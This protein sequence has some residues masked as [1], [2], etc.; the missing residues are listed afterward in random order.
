VSPWLALPGLSA[1]HSHLDTA[2]EIAIAVLL[3]IYLLA[4]LVNLYIPVVS[5][6]HR[7]LRLGPIHLIREFHRCFVLL[8]RDPLG[9]VSLAVTT[10]F[11]GAGATLR[12]IILSW[13]ALALGFSLEQATQLTAV[14]AV[15]IAIGSAVAAKTV[16]IEDSVRVLPVG[17][18]MGL[19]VIAM[20][21]VHQPWI[22]LPLLVVIGALGGYFVVPMNALLQHRGH[23]LMGAGHSIAVQNFN[24]NLSI[25]V[26][27]GVYAL[28]IHAELPVYLTVVLFGLFVSGSMTLIWRR[29]V[30][31][32]AS[33]SDVP[34]A[35]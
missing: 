23:Q 34:H 4:S 13:S 17:I 28:M 8:W 35:D 18:A 30:Q 11:W 9:R 26:L 10:L 3:V 25:V 5:A 16:S 6:K 2:P 27:L 14:V 7:P 29:H 21:F 12:L 33:G 22:A 32:A 1:L 31:R 20:T 19:A 15:G 24:E